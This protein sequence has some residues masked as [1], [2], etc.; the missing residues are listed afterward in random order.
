MSVV[1][2]RAQ[3]VSPVLHS[4]GHNEPLKDEK[5]SRVGPIRVPQKDTAGSVGIR[6]IFTGIT[7]SEDDIAWWQ[8]YH[9]VGTASSESKTLAELGF[10]ERTEMLDYMVRASGSSNA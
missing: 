1:K 3:S 8:S 9:H 5:L 10:R 2:A 7:G 4:D 6:H